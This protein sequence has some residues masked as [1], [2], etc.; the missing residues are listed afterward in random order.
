MAN[1]HTEE[2]L[3]TLHNSLIV[4]NT[5]KFSVRI[6]CPDDVQI[7]LKHVGKNCSLLFYVI[8]DSVYS[9]LFC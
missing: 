2:L 4:I 9:Q 6:D 1:L 8:Y 3:I 7:L 5:A